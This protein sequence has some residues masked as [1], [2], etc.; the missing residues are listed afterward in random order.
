MK[1]LIVYLPPDSASIDTVL[2]PLPKSCKD[3]DVWLSQQIREVPHV[4]VVFV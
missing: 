2:T 4:V 1:G 3:K